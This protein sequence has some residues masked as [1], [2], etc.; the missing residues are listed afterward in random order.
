MNTLDRLFF[1]YRDK[2]II[3][4][5]T[6]KDFDNLYE[7]LV[8]YFGGDPDNV[9]EFMASGKAQPYLDKYHIDLIEPEDFE[10]ELNQYD[11][12]KEIPHRAPKDPF[13]EIKRMQELA[14]I[15]LEE[16]EE[17]VLSPGLVFKEEGL[18]N[19]AAKW[20]MN[21]Q[22]YPMKNEGKQLSKPPVRFE[23]K[24]STVIKFPTQSNNY[25]AESLKKLVEILSKK[26]PAEW[27]AAVTE[28]KND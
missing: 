20:L 23:I 4:K 10:I 13:S 7:D 25:K 21:P 6:D 11:D 15:L 5:W 14:G 26:M 8:Q 24:D 28:V 27:G 12:E 1:K 19:M 9:T 2:N 22:N 3:M 18:R 16:E 17:E